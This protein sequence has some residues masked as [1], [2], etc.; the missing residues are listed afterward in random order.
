[1][2]IAIA[3]AGVLL[4]RGA[5]AQEAEAAELV[6]LDV[7]G[8]GQEFTVTVHAEGE[9]ESL[10]TIA[11]HDLAS[12]PTALDAGNY[13]MKPT[14]AGE[15]GYLGWA[16]GEAGACPVEPADTDTEIPLELGAGDS[17][18]LCVYHELGAIDIS[19]LEGDVS[20][21]GI[22]A[23]ETPQA[24]STGSGLVE[25]DSGSYGAPLIIGTGAALALTGGAAALALRRRNGR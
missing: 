21:E 15:F 2:V 12:T 24:P 20:E 9:T 5:S 10:T 6:I 8:D 14:P 22:Q 25:S 19:N 11:F 18:L 23:A 4:Q 1:M 16:M 17:A 13:T 7:G 3:V